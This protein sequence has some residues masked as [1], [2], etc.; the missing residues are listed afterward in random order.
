M[1]AFV[2][3]ITRGEPDRMGLLDELTSGSSR[4][5]DAM[6]VASAQAALVITQDVIP[7]NVVAS[8]RAQPPPPGLETTA[9]I[10]ED[11]E[12]DDGAELYDD[13]NRRIDR[14]SSSSSAGTWWWQRLARDF[15]VWTCQGGSCLGEEASCV[16]PAFYDGCFTDP[17]TSRNSMDR[18]NSSSLRLRPLAAGKQ[19]AQDAKDHHVE[20][21]EIGDR[22]Q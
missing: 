19:F 3:V 18:Q 22:A 17:A 6:I 21:R 8:I 12:Y 13:I 11:Y 10:D 20:A 5:N 2:N 4:T 9:E 16:R 7:P 15:D 1:K 14:Q